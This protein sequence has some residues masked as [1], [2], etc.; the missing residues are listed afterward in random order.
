MANEL[1]VT[2]TLAFTKAP[3]DQIT[4]N[5]AGKSFNVAGTRYVRGV[6]NVDTTPEAIGIGEI[7]APGWFFIKN[8][9]A[10]N[11]VEILTAAAGAAFLRLKPGEFAVG[12][13][14]V[15]APAA[16]ANVAAVNIEFMVV[17]D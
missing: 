6:Q 10:S 2:G 1:T 11:Y 12:R 13:F 16:Q 17:E 7:T 4:M 5:V 15:T 3:V 8:L 14:G 9:D